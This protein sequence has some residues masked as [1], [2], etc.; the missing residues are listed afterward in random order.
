RVTAMTMPMMSPASKTSRKTMISAAS[1]GVSLLHDQGAPGRVLVEVVKEFVAPRRKRTQVDGPFPV[2][3]NHLFHP[4]S[5][6][7]EFG[8]G[9][10]EIL[11]AQHDRPVGRGMQLGRLEFVI[12]NGNR[13]AHRLLG[14]RNG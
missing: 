2:R 1:T 13:K 12:A 6:A 14:G 9:G 3:R 7:F 10:I 8:R 11:D 4:Q 5:H